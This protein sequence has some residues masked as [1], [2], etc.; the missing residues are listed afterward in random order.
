ME[1]SEEERENLQKKGDKILKVINKLKTNNNKKSIM[2]ECKNLF[3]FKDFENKLDTNPYLIGF[4]NGVYDLELLEFR[5]GRP[6]DYLSM[7]TEIDYIEYDVDDPNWLD[8]KNFI[9]TVFPDEDIRE[10]FLTFLSSCLQGV[11]NEEKFRIWIGSGSNGK[12]KI[13]D[14]I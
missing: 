4:N 14:I 6:D 1:L 10:Y 7:N 13:E 3:Y 2:D 12:S 5:D 9:Y 11:N 8:L